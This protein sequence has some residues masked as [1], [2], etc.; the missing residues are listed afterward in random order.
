MCGKQHLELMCPELML[1]QNVDKSPKGRK[2]QKVDNMSHKNCLQEVV[3]QT[4]MVKLM[5][6]N[7]NEQK[8]RALIQ[9]GSQ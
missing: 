5:E 6:D 4:L 7:G 2:E 3:L 1:S 8:V 9:S